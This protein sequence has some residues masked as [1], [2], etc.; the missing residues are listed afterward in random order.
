LPLQVI[1]ATASGPRY[2]LPES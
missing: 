1:E 2:R